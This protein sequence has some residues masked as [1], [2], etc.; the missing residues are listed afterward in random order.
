MHVVTSLD[1]CPDP[2]DGTV[3]TWKLNPGVV[4]SDGEPFTSQDVV[5]TYHMIMDPANPVIDRGDYRVIES[6]V[7]LDRTTVTVTTSSCT[8]RICSHSHAFSRRTCSMGTPASQPILTIGSP[9]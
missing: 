2:P 3:V 9:A 7:A 4:W 8:H 6:V 1:A 5:F